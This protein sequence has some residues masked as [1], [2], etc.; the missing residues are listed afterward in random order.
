M[1]V[2]HKLKTE[3]EVNH[4]K[5]EK[6]G[7]VIHDDMAVITESQFTLMKQ[8]YS[9]MEKLQDILDTRIKLMEIAK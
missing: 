8:Q 6:L 3:S 1:S 5:L 7:M 9:T 4:I 2:L